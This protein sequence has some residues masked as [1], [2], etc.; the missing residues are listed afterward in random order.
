[1]HISLKL[2]GDE[3]NEAAVADTFARHYT[4]IANEL[5][6]NIEVG[7]NDSSEILK[8]IPWNNSCIF[9]SPAS[10]DEIFWLLQALSTK[11]AAG[12]DQITPKVMKNCAVVILPFVTKIVNHS[13]TSGT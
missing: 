4:T 9:L 13:L 2:D 5:A 6:L 8:N 10:E 11:K 1:M 3:I 12:V 7:P